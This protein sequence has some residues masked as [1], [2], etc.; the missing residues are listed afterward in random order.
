[1]RIKIEV[2]IP[3]GKTCET[4]QFL[5]W[6]EEALEYECGLFGDELKRSGHG[7]VLKCADCR[8]RCKKA[9]KKEV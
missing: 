2:T 7:K 5:T 8:S 9:V 4:C 3:D 6:Y 1:M